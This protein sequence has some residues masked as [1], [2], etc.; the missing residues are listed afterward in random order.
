[1]NSLSSQTQKQF[2]RRK[3]KEPRHEKE[4][5][6]ENLPL[7]DCARV[8]FYF[9]KRFLSLCSLVLSTQPFLSAQQPARPWRSSWVGSMT[10]KI[11]TPGW[12]QQCPC[13]FYFLPIHPTYPCLLPSYQPDVSGM[14]SSPQCPVFPRKSQEPLKL[15]PSQMRLVADQTSIILYCNKLLNVYVLILQSFPFVFNVNGLSQIQKIIVNVHIQ[16]LIPIVL[17]LHINILT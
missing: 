4:N 7:G 16:Y 2:L 9:T 11:L 1:M 12:V 5:Y 6:H 8:P 10:E 13:N 17:C 14:E 15:P 3:E